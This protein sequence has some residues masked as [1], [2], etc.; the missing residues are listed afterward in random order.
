MESLYE[1]LFRRVKQKGAYY[2]FLDKRQI[3]EKLNLFIDMKI[4]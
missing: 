2:E 4:D 1:L 3:V